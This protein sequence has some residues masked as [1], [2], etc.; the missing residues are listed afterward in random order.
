M[1]QKKKANL[2]HSATAR[3]FCC[4]FHAR[5]IPKRCSNVRNSN[6]QCA[7]SSHDVVAPTWAD[8]TSSGFQISDHHDHPT[9]QPSHVSAPSP[10]RLR[11]ATCDAYFP[12]VPK[13]PGL[14]AQHMVQDHVTDST[15]TLFFPTPPPHRLPH[16]HTDFPSPGYPVG[17]PPGTPRLRRRRAP[18]AAP[19]GQLLL[20]ERHGELAPRRAPG[21]KPV[22]RRK[23]RASSCGFDLWPQNFE[24]R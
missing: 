17:P 14:G 1:T 24:R 19:G 7:A 6:V 18:L 13:D 10:P 12:S 16:H 5:P 21:R 23:H 22:G 9:P 3:S 2:H 15:S 11:R 20:R 8:L 4:L